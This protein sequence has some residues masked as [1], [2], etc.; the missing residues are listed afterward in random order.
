VINQ[1][2]DAPDTVVEAFGTIFPGSRF[3]T[4]EWEGTP[5]DRVNPDFRVVRISTQSE[6]NRFAFVSY[7][8]SSVPGRRCAVRVLPSFFSGP[9]GLY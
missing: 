3:A 2:S 7:G 4:C 1:F 8:A 6:P 5:V 9:P